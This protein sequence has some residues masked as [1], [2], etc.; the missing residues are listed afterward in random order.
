MLQSREILLEWNQLTLLAEY[1]KDPS[2]NCAGTSRSAMMDVTYQH[3][4]KNSL[5]DDENHQDVMEDF[6]S[7]D[8][9][10]DKNYQPYNNADKSSPYS[11]D[12]DEMNIDHSSA[13]N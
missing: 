8:N 5:E 1:N 4:D 2:N 7:G 6:D 9:A 3:T 12:V 13:R 11:S 10:K